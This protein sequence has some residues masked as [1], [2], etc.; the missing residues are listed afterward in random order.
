MVII[1]VFSLV[2]VSGRNCDI[3][4]YYNTILLRPK[5]VSDKIPYIFT[6]STKKEKT[7]KRIANLLLPLLLLLNAA[8]CG[9]TGT[10]SPDVSAAGSPLKAALRRSSQFLTAIP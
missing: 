7:M 3:N 10:Q 8:A 4:R 1:G 5:D 6:T 2:E 9:Q